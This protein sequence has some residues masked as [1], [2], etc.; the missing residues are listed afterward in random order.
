MNKVDTN[1][2]TDKYATGWNWV[3]LHGSLWLRLIKVSSPAFFK[4]KQLRQI[5]FTPLLTPILWTLFTNILMN[6]VLFCFL[7]CWY[8]IKHWTRDEKCPFK[9]KK[10][11]LNGLYWIVFKTKKITLNGINWIAF[12]SD[13]LCCK[14]KNV[15]YWW[16]KKRFLH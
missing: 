14:A 15:C 11:T 16:G 13:Y 2:S 7:I 9:T 4:W 1:S 12:K 5:V 6:K 10:I 8:D 3:N